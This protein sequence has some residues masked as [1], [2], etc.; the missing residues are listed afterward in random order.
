MLDI[1][2]IVQ[3]SSGTL[4]LDGEGKMDEEVVPLQCTNVL[5]KVAEE[6]MA[7]NPGQNTSGRVEKLSRLSKGVKFTPSPSPP[8][9]V[10]IHVE[11]RGFWLGSRC[12]ASI[13][14]KIFHPNHLS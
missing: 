7:Y 13:F 12:Q 3:L 5:C 8:C 11:M 2:S 10:V 9:N 14:M 1:E 4:S 6:A